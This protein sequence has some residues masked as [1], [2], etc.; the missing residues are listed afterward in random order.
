MQKICTEYFYYVAHN[1]IN[2]A[3]V[4]SKVEELRDL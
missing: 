3:Y 2:F 1:R 4:N